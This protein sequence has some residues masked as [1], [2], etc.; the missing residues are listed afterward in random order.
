MLYLTI[1]GGAF[2]AW[3]VLVVLFT[4]HIP[5][6]IEANVDATGDRFTH[7]LESTC[8]TALKPGNKIEIFTNGPNFYPAMLD[9]IRSA[10]ESINME[11]YIFKKGHIGT[12][13]IE[14]LAER[15]R[16]GVRVTLVMDAIGSFGAFRQSAKPL[17]E[18]GC[19]V[20]AYQKV[21]WYRL[22]R[23]NNRTHRELLVVDGRIAFAGGAGVADWWAGPYRAKPMWRDMMVRIEGPVVSNVQGIVAEN[24][25]ECCGE[26]LTGPETYKPRSRVGTVPAFAIKSSPADR[27]TSSRILFQTMVEGSNKCVRIATPYFLPDKA[28]RTAIMR[29]ANRG[30]DFSVVVPGRQTDQL[31]VR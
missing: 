17:R 25:L 13:F 24:W 22:G 20:E 12:Q 11:C 7:V 29:T 5:Y 6:H 19:R 1:I 14:A 18:A 30:V 8:L 26:I 2:I 28:F 9:A 23:M 15:G 3:L 16:A 27:A 4:P 21:T 31:W 10:R